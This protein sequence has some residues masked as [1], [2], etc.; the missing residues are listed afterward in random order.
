MKQPSFETNEEWLRFCIAE[1]EFSPT[2]IK[3]KY[4]SR[5]KAME[6]ALSIAHKHGVKYETAES[7]INETLFA[8]EVAAYHQQDDA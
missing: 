8:C 1:I 3:K 4:G 6:V 5:E 7:I 2:S